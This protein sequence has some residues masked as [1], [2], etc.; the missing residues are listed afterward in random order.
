MIHRERQANQIYMT[1]HRMKYTLFLGMEFADIVCGIVLLGGIFSFIFFWFCFV[2]SPSI[3]NIGLGD[4]SAA[5]HIAI[6]S[7]M[8][9][10]NTLVYLPLI[11]IAG[12]VSIRSHCVGMSALSAPPTPHRCS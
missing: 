1:F 3:Y 10:L 8:F 9:V 5:V 11:F 7:L 6:Y 12:L 2:I 4:E